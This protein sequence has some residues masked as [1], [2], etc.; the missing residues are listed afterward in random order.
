[1]GKRE[2]DYDVS[3]SGREGGEA[4]KRESVWVRVW[5]WVWEWVWERE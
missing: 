5:V 2:G 4:R 1:M 3:E